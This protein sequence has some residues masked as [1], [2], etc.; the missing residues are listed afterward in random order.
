MKL[1]WGAAGI[2]VLCLTGCGRSI[3]ATPAAPDVDAAATSS[4]DAV[5]R[6]P[7]AADAGRDDSARK[8]GRGCEQYQFRNR[9][10]QR[11][12]RGRARAVR[13]PH[14]RG[15]SPLGCPDRPDTTSRARSRR[16]NGMMNLIAIDAKRKR[17]VGF[18]FVDDAYRIISI[19]PQSGQ[20][21]L[22][23]EAIA[24]IDDINS[25][26]MAVDGDGDRVLI[27]DTEHG[28]GS[29]DLASGAYKQLS[30][31]GVGPEIELVYGLAAVPHRQLAL[32]LSNGSLVVVDMV[33]G[34]RVIIS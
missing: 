33:T 17:V 20:R 14:R 7:S 3:A 30:G 22:V 18:G 6:P 10:Q 29:I 19:D 11:S 1:P 13:A 24:T 2:V 28:L 9:R 15:L 27:A 25:F 4:K 12:F 16:R 23:G 31:L 5:S 21:S 34:E 32:V 26:R 8:R